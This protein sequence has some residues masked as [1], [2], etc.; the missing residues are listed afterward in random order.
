MTLS[1]DMLLTAQMQ[2]RIALALYS[3]R[4]GLH[5]LTSE[6]KAAA[7]D[8]LY[9][10]CKYFGVGHIQA[11]A[12]IFRDHVHLSVCGTNDR[13]DFIDNLR[14]RHLRGVHRGYSDAANHLWYE[15]DTQRLFDETRFRPLVLGGHSAGGAIAQLLS[16]RRN[17]APREIV[18]FG[19]PGVFGR[20]AAASYQKN[21]W[22][23]YRFVFP[24]DPVPKLPFRQFRCLCGRA[25]YEHTAPALYLGDDGEV[26]SQDDA[27]KLKRTLGLAASLLVEGSASVAESVR[28]L[29][30]WIRRSHSMS[31]YA[32]AIDRSVERASE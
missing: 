22:P 11:G 2:A 31:R 3:G 17:M 29:P 20:R 24:G 28:L 25:T 23:H 10:Q 6:I 5:S 13:A 14:A 4:S 1:R 21:G 16:T 32:A 26:R 9:L 8:G 15:F 27:N 19:A 7:G 12:L 18:T 30:R